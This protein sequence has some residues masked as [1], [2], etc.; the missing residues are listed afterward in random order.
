[1]VQRPYPL[2][3]FAPFPFPPFPTCFFPASS[4]LFFFHRQKYPLFFCLVSPLVR[5]ALSFYSRRPSARFFLHKQQVINQHYTGRSYLP[6]LVET[7]LFPSAR[8]LDRD[9]SSAP[10]SLRITLSSDALLVC[11]RASGRPSWPIITFL[12]IKT[13]IRRF[14]RQWYMLLAPGTNI[15][16]RGFAGRDKCVPVSTTITHPRSLEFRQCG[17]WINRL[18]I[19]NLG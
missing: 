9:H 3:P 5:A 14:I 1:M 13:P 19:T 2:P 8:V 18:I 15:R 4:G 16:E 11:R 7:L 6:Y 12:Q 17:F 10:L